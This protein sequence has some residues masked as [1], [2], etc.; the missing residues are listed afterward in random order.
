MLSQVADFCS[1]PWQSPLNYACALIF[2]ISFVIQRSA[3]C[4]C[5]LGL[6]S[7]GAHYEIG[8]NALCCVALQ[9]L[10]FTFACPVFTAVVCYHSSVEDTISPRR[11]RYFITF[12]LL[13]WE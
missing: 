4:E 6:P 5:L 8:D 7:M 9:E 1:L 13:S 2:I 12:E 10:A 3:F 11:T